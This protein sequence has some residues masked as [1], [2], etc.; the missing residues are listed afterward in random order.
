ML[1]NTEELVP[2]YI[3]RIYEVILRGNFINENATQ[4]GFSE[5]YRVVYNNQDVLREYFRPLGYILLQRS[6]Y[7]YFARD[8]AEES[9]AVLERMVDY[10]DIVNF[11][12]VLDS[13]FTVG[14]RFT[15]NSIETQLNSS[16]ELQ[17]MASKMRGISI[18]SYRE[19]SDR[20]VE[21]LMKNGFI[22]EQDSVSEEYIVLNSYDYIESFMKEV[23]IYE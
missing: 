10:I 7:F 13:N 1:I 12:K 2:Q 11:L 6:G 17:D 21:R 3:K 22:E 14:Y 23:E 15:I 9:Q 5:L 20:I 19:F 8:D 16:V 18:K 4:D